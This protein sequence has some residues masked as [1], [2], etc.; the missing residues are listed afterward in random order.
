MR[1]TKL[2]KSEIETNLSEAQAEI[3]ATRIYSSCLRDNESPALVISDVLPHEEDYREQW[4]LYRP[5]IASGGIVVIE[6]FDRQREREGLTPKA[7]AWSVSLACL[8]R[9]GPD[10]YYRQDARDRVVRAQTQAFA[11]AG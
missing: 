9:V 11:E 3:D 10:D 7:L 8:V 1:R 2:T 4:T 6:Q 5:T